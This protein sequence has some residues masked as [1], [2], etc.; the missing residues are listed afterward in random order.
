MLRVATATLLFVTL[1]IMLQSTLAHPTKS[2]KR[3]FFDLD[4]ED[5]Y[6]DET[7]LDAEQQRT[8]LGK[9][10]SVVVIIKNQFKEI[11]QEMGL[12]IIQYLLYIFQQFKVKLLTKLGLYTLSDIFQAIF[13][14]VTDFMTDSPSEI[15]YFP[16][17]VQ[18]T[19][20]P[21]TA[22]LNSYWPLLRRD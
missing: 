10:S 2:E 4:S 11:I 20:E 1:C 15:L 17:Q 18:T 8:N 9:L 3:D 21:V 12:Q 5:S 14:R 22:F 19:S 16:D 6:E 7:I 13:D